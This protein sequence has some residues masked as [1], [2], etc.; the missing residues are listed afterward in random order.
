MATGRSLRNN[1]IDFRGPV[2]SPGHQGVYAGVCLH[3]GLV[4]VDAPGGLNLERQ[5][6]VF[7][8]I[9]ANLFEQGDL[10]NQVLQV[11]LSP[12]GSVE[13]SRLAMPPY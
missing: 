10:T 3:A 8:L 13:L 4:C 6:R 1:G 11:V 5:K 9:L 7:N 12:D 2:K